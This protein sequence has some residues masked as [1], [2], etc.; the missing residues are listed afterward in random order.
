MR[1]QS[2]QGNQNVQIQDVNRSRIE[3]TY[4]GSSRTVPLEPAHV[5]VGPHLRSPARLVR[6]HAGVVP[7]LD[8]AGLLDEL[9]DWADADVP[10]AGQVIGGHGGSGKTRLAI[11]LCRRLRE[12]GWLSGFLS[13][14][15]DPGMLDALVQVPT[16]RLVVVDYAESRVE[17]LELL[18]PLLRAEATLDAP[19]RILLLVR[20]AAEQVAEWPARLSNRIDALDAVLDECEVRALEE[21]PFGPADRAELFKA[22][23]EA[24]AA[25]SGD[26]SPAPSHSPDL[27]ED[28]FGSPLMIVIAA[29]LAANEEAAPPSNREELLEEVLAHERR[30]WQES[31]AELG[32]DEVL[33]SRAMAMATLAH[34]DSEA[35]AAGLLR[36]LPDLT[37]ASAE[38]LNRLARWLRSQYPGPRWWNPLEPDLLGEHLV[39]RS[40]FDQGSVLEKVL[41][42]SSPDAV[43]RPLEVLARSAADHPELASTLGPIL[44]V[45]LPHLCQ[46]AVKQAESVRDRG[47]LFGDAATAAGALAAAVK[48]VEVEGESLW[49]GLSILP[50]RSD[51]V[52]NELAMTLNAMEVELRRQALDG[53]V[54][55]EDFAFALSNLSNR[56]A[57]SG[58]TEQALAVVEEATHISRDLASDDPVSD[59]LNLAMILTNFSNRLSDAGRSEEAL[60]TI[61]E[62]VKTYRGLG[63]KVSDASRLAD[64]ALALNNFSNRLSEAE[65]S[66]EA[67][68]AAKESVEIFRSLADEDPTSHR[69]SLA[70]ALN[71][72]SS[73]LAE[74]ERDEEALKPIEESTAIRRALASDNPAAFAPGLAMALNNLAAHLARRG[75][76]DEALAAI[77]EAVQIFRPLVA[78]ATGV[79]DRHLASALMN[80]SN[81]QRE[82]GQLHE[83]LA[84]MEESVDAHHALVLA[85]PGVHEGGLAMALN[86]YAKL[87][88]Q[89]ERPDQ[90]LVAIE[91]S[92]QIRRALAAAN[93]ASRPELVSTLG[94]LGARLA[95]RERH[96]DA[97]AVGEEAVA[98]LRTLVATDPGFEFE[99]AATLSRLANS[100]MAVDRADDALAIAEEDV[101]VFRRLET[102]DLVTRDHNLTVA[103]RVLSECRAR[104]GDAAG[105]LAALEEAVQIYRPLVDGGRA[106]TANLVMLMNALADALVVAGR[107]EGAAEIREEAAAL[108][109]S[110]E[111][112]D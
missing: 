58:R 12:R 23:F 30:Y 38:R 96:Q 57:D 3:I 26:Q 48:T 92:A 73:R 20:M 2:V 105:S 64:W 91:T 45:A 34:A 14:I 77:E 28:A 17:Q 70:M 61:E 93:P 97:V 102:G 68:G 86:N 60:T 110:L 87:L 100:L 107:E 106:T 67:L 21:N 36:L 89:A 112:D 25:R 65:R 47:L 16:A 66:D 84:T 95:E 13:R 75:R 24:F 19:V 40:F 56:L 55:D 81:R 85:S 31:S 59:Q 5:P 94:I 104:T 80:L 41:A 43:A 4:Q 63:A 78:K 103:L 54:A 79:H 69:P 108:A 29:Y 82:A 62:A 111:M 88:G 42:S 98:L 11:E 10:F 49:T 6:A 46:V 7:Y 72:L 8:R 76:S 1:E 71:S 53:D 27:E 22:A 101:E 9:E 35:Q 18:M 37:D 74:V 51:V 15:A 90:A 33:L 39:A 99:L 52:L 109:P 50:Q 44:S 83:A 32:A